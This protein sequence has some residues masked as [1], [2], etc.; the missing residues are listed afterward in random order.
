MIVAVANE[1]DI[2][3]GVAREFLSDWLAGKGEIDRV[4]TPPFLVVYKDAWAALQLT[5]TKHTREQPLGRAQP[6]DT[7]PRA[8]LHQ[9]RMCSVSRGGIGWR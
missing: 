6:L 5:A 2:S 1:W 3:V 9:P 8:R 7:A 4:G